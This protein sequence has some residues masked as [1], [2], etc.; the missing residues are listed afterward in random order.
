M[1]VLVDGDR[2]G[3]GYITPIVYCLKIMQVVVELTNQSLYRVWTLTKKL[4][5]GRTKIL[6]AHY[7]NLPTMGYITI[8]VPVTVNKYHH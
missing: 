6:C 5:I 7:N 8:T 2:H 4:L 1:I 3:N